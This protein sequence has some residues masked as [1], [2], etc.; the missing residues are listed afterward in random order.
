MRDDVE[1]TDQQAGTLAPAPMF[2]ERTPTSYGISVGNNPTRRGPLRFEEG[3]GTDTDI[4]NSF[5]VGIS[6]G[7]VTNPGR[8]NQNANVYIK[9]PQ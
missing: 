6:Q 7:Y 5:Q 8:Y 1:P 4:P 2:P 3:L 9:T